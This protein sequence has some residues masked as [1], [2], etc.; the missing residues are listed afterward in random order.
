MDTV[1]GEVIASLVIDPAGRVRDGGTSRALSS[2]ED[3][4]RFLSLRKWANCI[5]VGSNTAAV[6]NY[7][8]ASLPVIIY[9]RRKDAIEDWKGEISRLQRTYGP[10]IL[11]EAGPNLLAELFD[12]GVIDSLYLT[13]TD[14]VSSDTTSPTFDT[15]LYLQEGSMKLIESRRGEE[16][17]FEIYQRVE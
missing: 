12:H 14:R 7:Q 9:S 6:E 2:A 4:Q 5:V 13:K 10:H 1:K 3:R 8:T 17:I 11:V 16:D 15:S